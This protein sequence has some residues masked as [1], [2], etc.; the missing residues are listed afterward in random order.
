ME[1]IWK[2]LENQGLSEKAVKSIKNSWAIKSTKVYESAWRKWVPYCRKYNMHLFNAT[3]IELANFIAYCRQKY[4][5]GYSALNT[6]KSAISEFIS[7]FV[8][9][10]LGAH[11]IVKRTLSGVVK[12]KIKPKY[13]EFW[14][15]DVL[16]DYWE[17]M[18]NNSELTTAILTQKTICIVAIALIGRSSDLSKL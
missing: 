14:D 12:Y 9:E 1:N 5:I 10:K 18:P 6:I 13:D 15:I 16:L 7:L 4:N 17:S 11:P 2:A 3:P 8:R